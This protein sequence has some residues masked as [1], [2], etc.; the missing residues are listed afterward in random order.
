MLFRSHGL[1]FSTTLFKAPT[2]R[3]LADLY[4]QAAV[5]IFPSL[6][7]G[8][9][10]PPLEAMACGAPVVTTACGGIS[11]FARDGEN[12]L[13]VP[14]ADADALAQAILRLLGDPHLR[15]RL[16]SAGVETARPWTWTRTVDQVDHFLRQVLSG[17][18]LP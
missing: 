5:F 11:E 12:C 16:S 18:L 1:P 14:P 7:E 8:F 17:G 4:R 10:L 9:G 6:F 13:M 2:D 3:Q 15:A